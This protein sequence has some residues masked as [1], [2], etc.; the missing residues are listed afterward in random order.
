MKAGQ[1]ER[2]HREDRGAKSADVIGRGCV[3]GGGVSLSTGYILG[4]CIF[5]QIVSFGT[6]LR[7]NI[8]LQKKFTVHFVETLKKRD[9]WRRIPARIT[10]KDGQNGQNWDVPSKVGRVATLT[11]ATSK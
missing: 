11:S 9:I 1:L 5:L 3:C 7:T 6:I 8:P 10:W 2:R 4:N